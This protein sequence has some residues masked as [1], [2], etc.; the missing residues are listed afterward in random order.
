MTGTQ[1]KALEEAREMLNRFTG[2][3]NLWNS[4]SYAFSF[5]N[6]I[7]EEI[8]SI[9]TLSGLSAIDFPDTKE[10]Y[11]FDSDWYDVMSEDEKAKYTDFNDFIQ[12]AERK[13]EA[14]KYEVAV[15]FKI[16]END[17]IATDTAKAIEV[18]TVNTRTGEEWIDGEFSTLKDAYEIAKTERYY[19][20]R[21]RIKDEAVEIRLYETA[22][23]LDYDVL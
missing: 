11:I 10:D 13:I 4:E 20:K 2:A 12:E 22:E 16:Y 8:N 21:D 1:A 18:V 9:L 3:K 14:I 6:F 23:K 15:A 19:L 7:D 17:I 5:W